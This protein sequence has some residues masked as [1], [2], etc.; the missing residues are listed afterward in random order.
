MGIFDLR[1]RSFK[2]LCRA[3]NFCSFLE[4]PGSWEAWSS[5]QALMAPGSELKW[6]R[7]GGGF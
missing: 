1:G 4:L 2:P 3:I 6:A 7:E 5:S